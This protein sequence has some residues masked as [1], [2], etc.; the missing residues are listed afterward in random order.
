M[1]RSKRLHVSKK[2]IRVLGI[3]E[4]FRRDEEKSVLAGVVMRSD[5]L[6][7]GVA[8]A[9][10]TVGGMDATEGVLRIFEALQRSDINVT[11]LNGCVISW[12]NIIDLKE[13]YERTKIPVICVTYEESEGLEEHI[14]KHFDGEERDCRIE[15]YKR[16]GRRI[17][18]ILDNHELLI[19]FL[20]MRKTEARAIIK[21]FSSEGKIPEVL[22]VAKIIARAALRSSHV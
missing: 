5:F 4:S 13:V 22:R 6:I 15:A 12:F 16:L 18:I 2:G 1:E 9:K 17:P 19:R 21:K 7:D 11:M 20:G 10:I 8:F 14:S 3:A